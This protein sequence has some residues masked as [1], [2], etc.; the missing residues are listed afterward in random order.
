MSQH[1]QLR[2]TDL[3]APSNELVENTSGSNI[4][5]LTVV[6]FSGLGVYPKITPV[7]APAQVIRGI[8]AAAIPNGGQGYITAL[9]LMLNI[10]T[11]SYN[12]G[13]KLYAGAGG[14]LSL[15]AAGLPVAYVLRKDVTFGA[16]YVANTGVSP[17]DIAAAGFPA[18]AELE[19]LFLVVYPRPYKEFVY[20][21]TGDIVDYNVYADNTKVI[22]LFNKHFAYDVGGNLITVATTNVITSLSK[23]RTISY[24]VNGEMVSMQET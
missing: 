17:D 16:L 13:D 11:N 6:M 4:S 15:A 10:N 19:M 22:Q 3:H 24:D 2:G 1:K 20:N 23:T 9:G 12:V 5:A 21:G 8:T 18:E 7:S 14:A